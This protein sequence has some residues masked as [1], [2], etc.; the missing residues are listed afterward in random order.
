MA[1]RFIDSEIFNDPW[2]MELKPTTKLLWIY[3]ITNC[4]HAGIIDLN[5]RLA[6]FQT[7]ITGLN[8]SWG[9][10]NQELGNRL[11]PLDEQYYFIPKFIDF[12]YPKGLS[13]SVNAQRSV[14]ER[15]RKHKILDEE[16]RTVLEGLTNPLATDQDKDKD[17]DKIKRAENF[18]SNQLSNASIQHEHYEGY[19]WIVN[20]M[21]GKIDKY[22]SPLKNVL[23]LRDQLTFKEF[24]GLKKSLS[25]NGIDQK[26]IISKTLRKMDNKKDLTTK[27][28]S[29]Y[30]TLLNWIR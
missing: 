30:K 20:F 17:I 21:F 13:E 1:K 10:V 3:L 16:N 2:F 28:V 5:L 25:E 24:C 19:D 22:P 4:D 26:G 8:K 11:I 12:Q 23:S 15:L 18:Y 14:I 7:G 6:E 27:Y 29:V 9:T